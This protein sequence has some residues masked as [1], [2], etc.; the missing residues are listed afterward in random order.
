M[1]CLLLVLSNMTQFLLILDVPRCTCS[2]RFAQSL[3]NLLCFLTTLTNFEIQSHASEVSRHLVATLLPKSVYS[4]SG[5][6]STFAAVLYTIS[7]Y[8]VPCCEDLCKLCCAKPLALQNTRHVSWTRGW[9]IT[10]ACKTIDLRM[11]VSGLKSLIVK[12]NCSGL[13]IFMVQ[14][15]P[16]E[17]ILILFCNASFGIVVPIWAIWYYSEFSVYSYLYSRT[18]TVEAYRHLPHETTIV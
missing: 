6:C 12:C 8:I 9:S 13:A 2:I 10:D 3:C 17:E 11:I 16:G 15:I 14:Y 1:T 7:C 4:H 18:C 5:L